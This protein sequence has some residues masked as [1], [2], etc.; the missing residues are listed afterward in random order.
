MPHIVVTAVIAGYLV[1]LGVMLVA[2]STAVTWMLYAWRTPAASEETAFAAEPEAAAHSFSLIVPARM[3]E[4]VLGDTLERLARLDHPWVQVVVVVG[5]DDPGTTAIAQEWV[6]RHPALGKLVVDDSPV[7]NKPRALNAALPHCTGDVVGVFDAEDEVHPQLLAHVDSLFTTSGA[8][9][10]QGGIQLMNYWSG[11]WA[12]RAVLEYYI[13]FRS[14]LHHDAA[15]GFL[16]LGGN[17]VFVRTALVRAAGGWDS[18]CLAE[19]CELG[20]RLSALGAR[21][22]V[23][24]QP[25]LVTREETPVNLHALFRQR[26]R[27]DQGFLQVLRKR[28]WAKLPTW[29]QRMFARTTLATPFLPLMLWLIV[30]VNVA[31]ALFLELPVAL[32]MLTYALFAPFIVNLA[33]EMVAYTEFCES[34]GLPTRR[35][36]YLSLIVSTPVYEVLLA[37]AAIFAI[38]RE[39]RGIRTWD[40]TEHAGAHRDTV[41]FGA[42]VEGA[43]AHI[44]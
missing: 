3:E 33:L 22:V 10:V 41:A 16:T 32:A 4:A 25:D 44:G 23:A 7:K 17:T 12:L 6:D 34:Y 30:P 38:V 40:K 42:S 43:G 8:D 2:V 20:V 5:D 39:R 24:Y 9:I 26:I 36:D 29:R 27:W 15:K 31:A 13:H 19:D 35:R 1:L 11:W 37:T 21:T 14:R 28:D 18:E